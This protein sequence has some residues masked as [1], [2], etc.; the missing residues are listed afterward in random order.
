MLRISDA[1]MAVFERR[2]FETRLPE[3]RARARHDH[4]DLLGDVPDH[5]IDALALATYD[6]SVAL[7]GL[8][9]FA[10]VYRLLE[11]NL[12]A[13]AIMNSPSA[14]D[15]FRAVIRSEGLSADQK[16]DCLRRDLDAFMR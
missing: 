12:H 4:A 14:R 15:Y 5:E 8:H 10:Q 16:V 13:S 1:Q 3:T 7:G 2:T 9:N 11:I 6:Q